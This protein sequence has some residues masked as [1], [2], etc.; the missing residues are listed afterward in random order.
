MLGQTPHAALDVGIRVRLGVVCVCS[1]AICCNGSRKTKLQ[2]KQQ[3]LQHNSDKNSTS[4]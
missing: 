2:Q 4:K 3:D 1:V